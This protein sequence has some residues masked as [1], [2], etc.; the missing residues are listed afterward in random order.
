MR[1]R[2]VTMSVM[3]LMATAWFAVRTEANDAQGVPYVGTWS[4]S[5]EGGGGTGKFELI[6]QRGADGIVDGNV[7]YSTPDG[8]YTAKLRNMSFDSK[9]F[10]AKYDYALDER[11]EITLT[12]VFDEAT[13][14]G[15]WAL[16]AKEAGDTLASGTWT[17]A[18]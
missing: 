18:K 4:G 11:G 10:M 17:A 16:G 6:L 15:T 9:K 1:K 8:D 3:A 5:W 2:W 13:A 12:A 7:A 14:N